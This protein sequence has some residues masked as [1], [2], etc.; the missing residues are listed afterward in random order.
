M[1]T[2]GDSVPRS[3]GGIPV[4]TALLIFETMLIAFAL[5]SVR[6]EVVLPRII[7]SYLPIRTIL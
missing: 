5:L 3:P 6:Y 1:R 2:V 4:T 7:L